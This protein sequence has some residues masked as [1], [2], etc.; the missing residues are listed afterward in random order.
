[1][2]RNLITLLMFRFSTI[3]FVLLLITFIVEAHTINVRLQIGNPYVSFASENKSKLQQAFNKIK[4]GDTLCVVNTT[5][6]ARLNNYPTQV[7]Y[8]EPLTIKQL[9]GTKQQP[10]T[11]LLEPGVLLS[12]PYSN[13]PN[14]C[15]LFW[16]KCEHIL[17]SAYGAQLKMNRGS[18]QP[19]SRM[20]IRIDACKNLQLQGCKIVDAST[21]GIYITGN[22]TQIDL[23]DIW[24]DH[25]FRNGLSII[26]A[27][28][29]TV[30][31]C[32]FTHSDGEFQAE[33]GV[34]IEPNTSTDHVEQIGFNE[35]RFTDN[36]SNGIMISVTHLLGKKYTNTDAAHPISL[37]ASAPISIA[38]NNCYIGN[39]GLN[40][41]G[42]KISSAEIQ[43]QGASKPYY[44]AGQTHQYVGLDVQGSIQFT[45]CFVNNSL[46]AALYIQKRLPTG[47]LGNG[48]GYALQFKNCVFKDVAQQ[49]HS[50]FSFYSMPPDSLLQQQIPSSGGVQFVDCFLT[51]A[52]ASN[53]EYLT[54]N[55]WFNAKK[56]NMPEPATYSG[57]QFVSSI[58]NSKNNFTLFTD[59]ANTS[60][61]RG[62]GGTAKQDNQF[63]NNATVKNEK[64]VIRLTAA[65]NQNNLKTK[66]PIATTLML[67]SSLAVPYPIAIS[68]EVSASSYLG[69]YLHLPVGFVLLEPLKTQANIS[70]KA[71]SSKTDLSKTRFSIQLSNPSNARCAACPTIYTTAGIPFPLN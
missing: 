59:A 2:K 19:E 52:S 54:L 69:N 4:A 71:L 27:T 48:I 66:L 10:I 22:S 35:C 26:S 63:P 24:C 16:L 61:A 51:Y 42:F 13:Q 18:M 17:F 58:A 68:Y 29:L 55:N 23:L 44:P 14:A 60:F 57:I 41:N 50:P 53:K 1:M 9:K 34:D 37:E 3:V 31:N 70:L 30:S 39:N 56:L 21:D 25:S 6:N 8:T 45:N 67:S 62:G 40:K 43:V 20:A 64:P 11:V 49:K 38:F 36:N 7:F 46:N 47:V 33:W 65:T 12:C 32:W 28:K 15:L 5:K